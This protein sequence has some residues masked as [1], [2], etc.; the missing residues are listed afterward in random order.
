MPVSYGPKE[1]TDVTSWI[2]RVQTATG[3]DISYSFRGAVW[4]FVF[5]LKNYQLWNKISEI[6]ILSGVSNLNS[7]LVKLKYISSPSATFSGTFGYQA[8]GSTAGIIGD[9]SSFRQYIT[10]VSSSDLPVQNRFVAAYETSRTATFYGTII[11]REGGGGNSAFGPTIR[12]D[13]Q[14][15]SRMLDVASGA[16]TIGS[17]SSTSPGGLLYSGAGTGVI[18]TYS[19]KT[20][21]SQNNTF[22]SLNGLGGYVI[23]GSLGGGTPMYSNI[24]L[25]MLGNYLNESEVANLSLICD[26]FML[27]IGANK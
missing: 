7:T 18:S 2:T 5:D 27:S 8:T 1:D 21:F 16:T 9:G 3:E 15:E 20:W 19:N 12:P 13:G 17:S 25:G 23:G 24:S 6:Y 14:I 10:G 4:K 26:N 22:G 11:G